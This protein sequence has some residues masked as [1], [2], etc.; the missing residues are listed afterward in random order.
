MNWIDQLRRLDACSEA[1]EWAEE[2]G[3]KSLGRAW[4][5]CQRGDW[6][7][8]LAGHMSGGPDSDARRPLVLAACECARLALSAFEAKHPDD[9]RPRLAIETAE[10]WARSEDGVSTEDVRAAADAAADAAYAAAD[11]AYAAAYAAYAAAYAAADAAAYAADAAYAAAD[12]AVYAAER[13]RVLA[14]CSD[15]V[16]RHYPKPPEIGCEKEV[17]GEC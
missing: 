12:T 2:K 3:Y 11:A 14:E 4:R 8:W 17:D 15:I 6:M 16:R 13:T 9:D 10:K 1:V 5:Y 7:L